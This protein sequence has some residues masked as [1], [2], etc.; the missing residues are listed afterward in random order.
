MTHVHLCF[1]ESVLATAHAAC[2]SGDASLSDSEL[3]IVVV[4]EDGSINC[5]AAQN[6]W[7]AVLTGLTS[8]AVGGGGEPSPL[9]PADGG[10]RAVVVVAADPVPT[11]WTRAEG[12]PPPR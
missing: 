9:Q 3:L 4:P 2:L 7:D 8:D 11:Q 1:Y 12:P 10:L 5:T 6:F